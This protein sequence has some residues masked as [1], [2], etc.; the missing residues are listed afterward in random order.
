MSRT[1][2]IP[3]KPKPRAVP[4]QP[5]LVVPRL[6]AKIAVDDLAYLSNLTSKWLRELSHEGKLPGFTGGEFD[7]LPAVQMLF[8]Y[9]QTDDVELK[10]EKLAQSREKT[11]EMIR[12]N[13]EADGG[14]ISRIE[15]NRRLV[16]HVR[17]YHMM[18]RELKERR[19]VGERFNWLRELKASPEVCREFVRRDLLLAQKQIDQIEL[20]CQRETKEGLAGEGI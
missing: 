10:A 16:G 4:S 9:Y 11:K 5:D 12:D 13:L 14:L 15:S 8:R 6:P 7:F 18:V 19:C 17:K 2:N 1:A 20:Q 3:N